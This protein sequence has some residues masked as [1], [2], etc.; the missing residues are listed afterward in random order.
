[1]KLQK[2]RRLFVELKFTF[3]NQQ[4]FTNFSFIFRIVFFFIVKESKSNL[5][6]ERILHEKDGRLLRFFGYQLNLNAL[7]LL[8][9]NDSNSYPS[10][11]NCVSHAHEN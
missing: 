10:Y 5:V 3:F 2:Q 9:S 1:M 6:L 7:S 11:D 4:R 8:Y